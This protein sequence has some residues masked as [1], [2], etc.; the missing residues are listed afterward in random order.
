ME[1]QKSKF[2]EAKRVDRP[3]PPQSVAAGNFAA[4]HNLAS[5]FGLDYRAALLTILVD[6]LVFGIDTLSMETLLPLGAI[7][8]AALGLVVYQIQIHHGKDARRPALIKSMIVA[9]L[10][11]APV[12]IT[13]LFSVPAGIVSLFQRPDDNP[14]DRS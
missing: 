2:V 11:F 9:I 8:A 7:L 3:P 10:T 13:P 4:V 5:L 1:Q 6:L 14:N 12:P